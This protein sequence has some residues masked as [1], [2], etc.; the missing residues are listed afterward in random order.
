MS[1]M[2]SWAES[3]NQDISKWNVSSVTNMQQMFGAAES[4]NQDIGNWDVSNVTNMSVMFNYAN[5]FN[6]DIGNWDV[7]N[8]TNMSDMFSY[9]KSFNQDI[10]NWDVSNVTNMDDMFSG[11]ESFDQDLGNWNIHKDTLKSLSKTMEENSGYISIDIEGRTYTHGE[12]GEFNAWELMISFGGSWADE[13]GEH[14]I[15]EK[16]HKQLNCDNLIF[17]S[18]KK[19]NGDYE[20]YRIIDLPEIFEADFSNGYR[21]IESNFTTDE[22]VINFVKNLKTISYKKL[23]PNNE[24]EIELG[25]TK[26]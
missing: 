21:T 4:F 24:K 26:L 12:D 10:G 1:N 16:I 6:Q 9:T 23:N 13:D 18:V 2:F 11:A 22:D 15:I 19:E 14:E 8:V 5:S 7:S 3:F 25:Y 17:T 20:Y